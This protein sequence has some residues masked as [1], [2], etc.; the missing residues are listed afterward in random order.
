MV[1]S[2]PAPPANPKSSS[3]V[4]S[5][6]GDVHLAPKIKIT[7]GATP[8]LHALCRGA[9]HVDTPSIETAVA[10]VHLQGPVHVQASAD[11]DSATAGA[12][13]GAVLHSELRARRHGA[14]ATHIEAGVMELFQALHRQAPGEIHLSEE[15]DGLFQQQ[16]G[17][18]HAAERAIGAGNLLS[19]PAVRDDVAMVLGHRHKRALGDLCGRFLWQPHQN[20]PEALSTVVNA[21]RGARLQHSLAVALSS[22]GLELEAFSQKSGN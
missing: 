1:A 22:K 5:A 10:L 13:V 6:S 8:R 15:G 4:C 19:I 21:L 12:H 11:G 14:V 20:Y 3:S 2:V 18:S 16:P 7:S 17:A 9:V